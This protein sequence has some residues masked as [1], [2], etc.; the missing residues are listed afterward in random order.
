MLALAAG[1]LLPINEMRMDA[2][3]HLQPPPPGQRSPP[4]LPTGPQDPLAAFEMTRLALL[5]MYNQR[6]GMGGEGIRPPMSLPNMP[7]P[8]DMAGLHQDKVRLTDAAAR[9]RALRCVVRP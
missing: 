9:N 7:L 6:E 1:W 8:P 3:L 2:R 5:K 4:G